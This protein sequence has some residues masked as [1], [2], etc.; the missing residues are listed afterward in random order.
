MGKHSAA[1]AMDV[2]MNDTVD[3]GPTTDKEEYE[4]LCGLV[5]FFKH[6]ELIRFNFLQALRFR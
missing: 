3:E 1:E 6:L 5:L 4:R 2:S